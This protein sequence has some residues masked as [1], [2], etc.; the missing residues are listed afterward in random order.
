[1]GGMA[2][3]D[4]DLPGARMRRP[5]RAREAARTRRLDASM[6]LLVE[7]MQHPLDPG[8]AAAAARRA[9]RR[10]GLRP[11]SALVTLVVAVVCGWV[12]TTAIVELRRPQPE[13]IRARA[14]L[15]NEIQRR[16]SEVDRLQGTNE[17]LRAEI[18]AAQQSALTDDGSSGLAVTSRTLAV[19]TGELPVT[20]RGLELTLEDAVGS[21]ATAGVDPRVT[22]D[23]EQGRVMDRDLQMVVNGLWAA[24]AEAIAINGER[25]TALSA[26]RSAGQAILVDFRPLSPPYVIDAVGDPKVLQSGFGE[27]TAG[28]YLKLLSDSYGIRAG[29]AAKTSMTLP[30]AGSLALRYASVPGGT[31]TTS[32]SP[33]STSGASGT[34]TASRSA[35]VPP[36]SASNGGGSAAPK[37]EVSP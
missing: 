13:A 2:A 10:P 6:T 19:V 4:T 12:T 22:G 25:L 29:M 20:G 5:T 34:G 11:L 23:T 3:S 36:S 30:G 32:S 37:Q 1:M 31:S 17:K 18:A 24:G 28:A 35:G 21:D 26:I 7:V 14:E 16:T 9:E 27:D 15:E 33:S 8:Y